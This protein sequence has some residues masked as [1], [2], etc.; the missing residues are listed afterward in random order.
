M[1][2]MPPVPGL[3][4]AFDVAVRVGPP[5]DHGMTRAGHRRVIPILGGRVTGGL[6]AEILPGGADWQ[7][8][9]SDGT[10]EIDAQYTARTER[11]ELL[12][13]HTRG[14]RHGSPE[15]LARLSR[16]EPVDPSEYYFRTD[17]TVETAAERLAHLEQA[18]FVAACV[19]DV[20]DVRYRCYRVT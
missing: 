7:V 8:I 1:T 9:R 19:R 15:V 10:I 4:Y 20:S 18:C 5:A 13:L 2:A 11:G 14:V 16:G 3:E 17:L 12:I 6:E